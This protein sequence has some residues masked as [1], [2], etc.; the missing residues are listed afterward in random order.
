MITRESILNYKILIN[1][2]HT[3]VAFLL[4]AMIDVSLTRAPFL[5]LSICLAAILN[6][7]WTLETNALT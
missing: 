7:N 6:F 5:G 3:S 2:K 1:K 4:A